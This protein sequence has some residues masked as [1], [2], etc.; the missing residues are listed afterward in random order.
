F[1]PIG[2][3][4]K[5]DKTI[6]LEPYI[7]PLIDSSRYNQ[8]VDIAGGEPITIDPSRFGEDTLLRYVMHLSDGTAKTQYTMM[9]GAFTQTN[10]TSDWLGDWVTF[11]VEDTDA[12]G[13][14]VRRQ[15]E[16]MDEEQDRRRPNREVIDVFNASL[17]LGVH[18]KNK[19]SLAAL[20]VALKTTINTTAPNTVVFR[21]FEP[22]HNITIVQIAPDPT[23]PFA[24][25]LRGHD[26]EHEAVP[27]EKAP[28]VDERGPALYYATIEDGFYVSTQAS[29]LRKLIDRLRG[30]AES[31]DQE[32]KGVKAN[33]MLYVA[34]RAAEL[35]RPTVSYFL[36]Q[37]ARQVSWQNLAQVWL[38][39]RCGLLGD[40][41]LDEVSRSYLGYRL[42][43]PDGGTYK[44]DTATGSAKSTV[45]GPLERPL[46]LEAS[47]P[48]SPIDRLLE[49]IELVTARVQFA[50]D[51]LASQVSINRR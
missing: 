18:S 39:G 9:L 26:A 42:V 34:P 3:R 43:C 12:F 45:H 21:N 31:G 23:S 19:L 27:G 6:T 22:Y 32:S 41:T 35:A 17:V 47:P 8:L 7:L 30:F 49:Q 46:R 28:A 10:I 33:A 37:R 16:S 38:L 4:I 15:Y 11:W 44:F 24:Q 48:G 50:E 2:I 5:L 1:D 14:L 29:A 13:T 36:E 20:L 25:E 51:G 40:R